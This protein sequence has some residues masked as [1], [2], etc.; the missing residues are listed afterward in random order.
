MNALLQVDNVSVRFGGLQALDDVSLDIAPGEIAGLIGPNGAGKT[1]L[2]N[3]IGGLVPLR[4][5]GITFD[6]V[7]IHRLPAHRRAGLGIGRS[8]Q[9]LGLMQEQTVETNLL[10]GLH[11]NAGY[12]VLS[13]LAQPARFVAA[14]GASRESVTAAL[15]AVGL[16]DH[17]Q[18]VV[19]DLSFGVARLVEVA[20]LLSRH[21][22]LLLLD[23]PTTGLDAVESEQLKAVL[24]DA[25]AS[26]TTLLVVA[27][28]VGFIMDL[29]RVV[30]VLAEGRVLYSGSPTGA[31]NDHRV[32]E[33]YLGSARR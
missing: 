27:H 8:F 24:R 29:C 20:G 18:R 15:D 22:Q 17:H 2:F 33:S 26:G 25:V 7:D 10:A 9:N 28:D 16:G 4:S 19:A 14:E 6:G 30:H 12:G 11:L 32:I 31:Q 3:A 5:G 13:P 1:T 23:E 21:P